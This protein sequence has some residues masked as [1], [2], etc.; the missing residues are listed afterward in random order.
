MFVVVVH[1][2][3]CTVLFA[4]VEAN[5]MFGEGK[6]ILIPLVEN[7]NSFHGLRGICSTLLTLVRE[8]LFVGIGSSFTEGSGS[9][10]GCSAGADVVTTAVFHCFLV[11]LIK[12]LVDIESGLI[13]SLHSIDS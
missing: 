9:G 1:D 3:H 6:L 5:D 7:D 11:R 8:R 12:V 2:S 10:V 4:L 13:E